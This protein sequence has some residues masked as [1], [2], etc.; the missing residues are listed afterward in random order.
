[1]LLKI[2]E[3]IMYHNNNRSRV[4]RPI[5]KTKVKKT[6]Y[7]LFSSTII[8]LLT[9][10]FIKFF[11]PALNSN[12]KNSANVSNDS[13]KAVWVENKEDT[14]KAKPKKDKEKVEDIEARD[15]SDAVIEPGSRAEEE[16]P[17]EQE[18]AS[19]EDKN[20]KNGEYDFKMDSAVG[21][22]IYYNQMDKRWAEQLYGPQDPIG[23]HG[24]GPTVM[25]TVVSS[26]TDTQ[27]NPKEMSDWAYEN[28][29]CA[30]GNG[31]S[32]ALIPETAK[33]FGLNVEPLYR[34]SAEDIR[35]ALNNGKIVV[36]LSG[37]GIFSPDDGHFF[38]IREIKPNGKVTISDSVKLE[39]VFMQWDIDTILS[40]ASPVSSAGGPF[41]AI[42]K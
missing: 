15:D 10:V 12:L 5:K 23:T 7:I 8:V 2:L 11:L 9:L 29:Y 6:K 17:E 18:S 24:C 4:R 33:A 27:M 16:K 42:S 25:A 22:L 13:G 35:T 36:A 3:D 30:V 39:H 14:I 28:G 38:I 19:N 26:L 1:M 41:W 20:K 21:S 32:H 31:S 40:Q 37:H 34:A